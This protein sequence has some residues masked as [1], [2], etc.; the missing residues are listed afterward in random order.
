MVY[1]KGAVAY[2]GLT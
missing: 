2:E 1:T